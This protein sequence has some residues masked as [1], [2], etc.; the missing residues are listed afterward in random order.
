M[1][2]RLFSLFLFLLTGCN[3]N[4]PLGTSSAEPLDQSRPKGSNKDESCTNIFSPET[5]FVDGSIAKS[6][7]GK[8]WEQAFVTIQEAV[9]AIKQASVI[10]KSLEHK[11]F[12][13]VVARGTYGPT[14][15][16]ST[17]Q[18]AGKA[19]ILADLRVQ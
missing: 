7:T 17:D 3:S 13:V 15:L 12:T 1:I 19:M 9:D 2:I 4:K 6:G 14:S 18:G 11:P 5:F 8:T 16:R 10:D